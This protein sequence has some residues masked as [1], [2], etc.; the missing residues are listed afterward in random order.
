[1]LGLKLNRVSKRGHRNSQQK[2]NDT[3]LIYF[4]LI[5]FGS[6][7]AYMVWDTKN[8]S[9]IF[10]EPLKAILHVYDVMAL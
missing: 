6:C 1:M 8:T 4:V 5:Y 10:S 2:G 9:C 7:P 3:L